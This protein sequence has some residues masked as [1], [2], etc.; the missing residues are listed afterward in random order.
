MS[1]DPT[2]RLA[3]LR[4]QLW[5]LVAG[6]FAGGF[7]ICLALVA[8]G[9]L[10]AAAR[11]PVLGLVVALAGALFCKRFLPARSPVPPAEGV[12]VSEDEEPR[13][14]GVVRRVAALVGARCALEVVLT[15]GTGASCQE[16]GR[17]LGRG[18]RCRVELGVAQLQ[19]VDEAQLEAL[20]ALHLAH[21]ADGDLLLR[22][23]VW[24]TATTIEAW[25]GRTSP[26]L[27]RPWRAYR[28]R[29]VRTFRA[30]DAVHV[31]AADAAAARAVGLSSYRASLRRTTVLGPVFEQ[32]LGE[33]VQPMLDEGYRPADLY[34]G[35]RQCLRVLG[36]LGEL[37]RLENEEAADKGGEG[38][39]AL[40]ARLA[41]LDGLGLQLHVLS[42]GEAGRPA[43]SLLADAKAVEERCAEL[44]VP[45]REA[46]G[47][48]KGT[49]RWD[50]TAERVWAPRFA[51]AVAAVKG[52]LP[53]GT[54][55]GFVID[56]MALPSSL[57]LAGAAFPTLL[58]PGMEADE[59]QARAR[60]L[61]GRAVAGW[62][63][64]VL[65]AR[66]WRWRTAPA[67][68]VELEGPDGN[69]F[70]PLAWVA[71]ALGD[72]EA[73]A[74]LRAELAELQVLD[75]AG[76]APEAPRKRTYLH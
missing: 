65:V 68:P 13:L 24:R 69:R 35:F 47:P 40:G 8:A 1:N 75:E 41:Y 67:C 9:A 14:Y 49:L 31:H 60:R 44:R 4:L 57:A 6:Y 19:S 26:P 12:P 46:D 52:A 18:R 39:P 45:P 30:W 42:A 16:V 23:A 3:R 5:T 33:E 27:A 76:P 55:L 63:G 20:L 54:S 58:E 43:R 70:A 50:E 7:A 66:G 61:L 17:L 62:I 22:R 10:L 74:R 48:P 37:E 72:A 25:A 36:E 38:F 29:L 51:R 2:R 11:L 15:P 73:A 53:P 28:E 32:F 56:W 71:P 34:G 59:R 64:E 21:Q